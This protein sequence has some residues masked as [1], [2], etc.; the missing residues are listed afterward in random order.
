MSVEYPIF[1]GISDVPVV[2]WIWGYAKHNLHPPPLLHLPHIP[3]GQTARLNALIFNHNATTLVILAWLAL[4]SSVCVS[5]GYA[6]V[7]VCI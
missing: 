6:C 2:D 1:L 5:Y 3:Q 4:F 7:H